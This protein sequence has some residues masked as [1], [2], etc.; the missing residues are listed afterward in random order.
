MPGGHQVKNAER[1]ASFDAVEV[2]GDERMTEQPGVLLEMTKKLVR[3]PRVR[4]DLAEK[5]HT[6]Y[7][8]DAA[9]D[10]AAILIKLATKDDADTLE[11]VDEVVSESKSSE[12][13]V[14]L[15]DSVNEG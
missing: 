14:S 13:S 2:I 10:L 7:K 9:K 4:K 8:P 3:S 6:M 11:I 1:L 5:L 12:S 15:E